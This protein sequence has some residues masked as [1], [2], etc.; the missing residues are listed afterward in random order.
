MLAVVVD[1]R[2]VR[3]HDP[4]HEDAFGV[5]LFAGRD[6]RIL[7]SIPPTLLLTLSYATHGLMHP[8]IE[9]ADLRPSRTAGLTLS[10]PD[11]HR[12]TVRLSNRPAPLQV[13]NAEFTW[14][15]VPPAPSPR[16]ARR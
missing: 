4:R 15:D 11:R 13:V 1:D 14:T 12:L 2:A 6:Q 10:A 5:T 7:V 8:R 16:R 3:K 9:T